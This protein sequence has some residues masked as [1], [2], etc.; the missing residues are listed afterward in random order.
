MSIQKHLSIEQV[1]MAENTNQ[2]QR[3]PQEQFGSVGTTSPFQL[4]KLRPQGLVNIILQ[5]SFVNGYDWHSLTTEH[6]PLY[7]RRK[8][9]LDSI[10]QA[11]RNYIRTHPSDSSLNEDLIIN[12]V[13]CYFNHEH[14]CFEGDIPEEIQKI[15][16]QVYERK[17]E[18]Y[19]V[20][21]LEAEPVV[22]EN[23]LSQIPKK[24]HHLED[25]YCISISKDLDLILDKNTMRVHKVST[26]WTTSDNQEACKNAA[27]TCMRW[28]F[29]THQ[30]EDILEQYHNGFSIPITSE[31]IIFQQEANKEAHRI[32]Q[33]YK[34]I[35]KP[36]YQVL[37]ERYKLMSDPHY[38]NL[39]SFHFGKPLHH[40][41]ANNTYP[42]S[43]PQPQPSAP[44]APPG[45]F[46]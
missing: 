24:T 11:I 29:S 6:D 28:Y 30:L 18:Q 33:Q 25:H 12:L 38:E 37:F 8:E 43:N 5:Y 3:P 44:P 45:Y 14:I 26:A 46:L 40:L 13:D 7:S 20:C 41:F 2:Q 34:A 39:C 35:Q 42:P 9:I 31:N 32:I 1:I 10:L 4:P 17:K 36:H 23:F 19:D 21:Q 16:Q 15:T 22:I 27:K